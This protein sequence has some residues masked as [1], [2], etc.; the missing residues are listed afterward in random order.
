MIDFWGSLPGDRDA[1]MEAGE[2][3]LLIFHGTEDATVPFSEAE[4]LVARAEEVGIEYGFFPLKGQG[5]GAWDNEV[6]FETVIAQALYR[7][8][9]LP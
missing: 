7:N 3:P 5:H 8:V 9:V 6:L 1:E 2:P 4:E